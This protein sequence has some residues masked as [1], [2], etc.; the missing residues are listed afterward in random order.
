MKIN[1][2]K[3]MN[4]LTASMNIIDAVTNNM[5]EKDRKE[6][7]RIEDLQED[8]TLSDRQEAHIDAGLCES[9]F[10]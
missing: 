2:G 4:K 1:E 3:E 5:D 6:D 8:N 7:A 10:L 9:D